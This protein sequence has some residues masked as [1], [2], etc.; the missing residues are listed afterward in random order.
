MCKRGRYR[1]FY[2]C[3]IDIIGDGE[4]NIIN[5]AQMPAVIYNTFKKLGFDNFVIHI[6]NRKILNGLFNSM[7]LN[8]KTVDIL[9]I[10]DKID[11]IGEEKVKGGPKDFE[12]SDEKELIKLWNLLLSMEVMK[13]KY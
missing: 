11:K 10:I 8:E 3:D 6:N 4:L 12:I 2:Q 7:D 13:K 5:D 9:R 1:E